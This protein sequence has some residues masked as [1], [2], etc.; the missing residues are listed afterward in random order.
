MHVIAFAT[1][2]LL[3]TSSFCAAQV[4]YPSPIT[5]DAYEAIDLQEAKLGQ[6]LFYD[7]ILSG[8]KEVACATCHHPRFG[9]SDGVSLSF[10]DGGTGFGQHRRANAE[11]LP[12][13]RIPRNS[14]AL[15]NLGAKEFTS[16]FHD[17]RLEADPAQP[18]GLRSPMDA[19]MSLGFASVLSAQT[20]FPVLSRDEMAGSHGENDIARL[21]R[22]GIITG[23]G[24]AWDRLARR[25]AGIDAYAA[26]FSTVYPHI[27]TADDIAFTDISNAIA[28]FMAHE[29][30]SDSAPFDA[31]LRG[32]RHPTGPAH[33]GAQLFYGAAGC[34]E[35][36]SGPFL[37][38]H[39]FHAMAAPQIG[40]GKAASFE[41]HHKDE[42][43]FRVTGRPEDLYAFRTPSL[44]NVALTGP[45]GHAGAHKD[46]DQFILDHADPARALFHYDRSQ[47]VLP[48]YEALDF[49]VMDDLHQLQAIA[50]AVQARPVQ[51]TQENLSD[52]IAFLDSLTD[53]IS[54]TGRLGIPTNLP[55][56]LKVP[57]GD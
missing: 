38:D 5:E 27:N 12:E 37:T 15:F 39:K 13:E 19:D 25:V 29:W 33:R 28:V 22:Q 6:L 52:L 46:L 31:V 35:C 44:R 16:L 51:L 9:T 26:Q 34:A 7:P 23:D 2:C 24:G 8:N 3:A 21:I 32:D 36:H 20:M 57:T 50:D 56:G 11:N 17:G 1:F 53:P 42:G 47:A 30:R 41:T 4:A 48:P 43:R 18:N 45:Y 14:P 55:S 40:P 49:A 10:G 54:V